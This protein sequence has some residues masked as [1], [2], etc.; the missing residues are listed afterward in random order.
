MASA[1][2][3]NLFDLAN[4]CFDGLGRQIVHDAS[5]VATKKQPESRQERGEGCAGEDRRTLPKGVDE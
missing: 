3:E 5:V 4:H 1:S 2:A